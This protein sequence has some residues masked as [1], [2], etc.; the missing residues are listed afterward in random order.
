[1]NAFA[2]DEELPAGRAGCPLGPGGTPLQGASMRD[3]ALNHF[4]YIA[5][6]VA[7]TPWKYSHSLV[8]A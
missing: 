1:V 5:V 8:D 6:K 4:G 2:G 3:A 7:S